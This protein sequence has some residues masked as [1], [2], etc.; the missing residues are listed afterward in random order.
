MPMPDPGSIT[1]VKGA[2]LTPLAQ[3]VG[4]AN[5]AQ[6]AEFNA[7]TMDA[8]VARSQAESQRSQ[9]GAQSDQFNLQKAQIQ[10]IE[11]DAAALLKDPRL[12]AAEADQN[13]ENAQAN[14]EKVLGALN[15]HAKFALGAGIPQAMVDQVLQPF[16]DMA[17][18]NPA[19]LRQFIM[20]RQLA[21]VGAQGQI[22]S[23]QP[24]IS[25]VDT[26]QNVVGVNTNQYAPQGPGAGV[27]TVQ[28]DV[29]VTQP[30]LLPNGQQGI[31]G[32]QGKGPIPTQLAP[33][34]A[35]A[36]PT[37]AGE[38]EAARQAL[39]AAPEMHTNNKMISDELKNVTA[40]GSAGGIISK[41]E[42]W[43]GAANVKGS[44]EA[45]RA[46]SAMDLIGKAFT[47]NMLKVAG[48]MGQMTN[49]KMAATAEAFGNQQFN[50]TAIRKIT[51]LNDALVSGAEAYQP[52]LEK[53]IA[54]SGGNVLAKRQYDQAWGQNFDPLVMQ[55]YNAK[56]SGNTAELND[57]LSSVGGPNSLQA[58]FLARK[59]K[60]LQMLSTQGR[61]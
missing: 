34:D 15:E 44:N 58:Q 60:N 1:P 54:A 50:P 41:A 47:R 53:A 56:K 19:N 17:Q 48:T 38:R 24:N 5:Q 7:R 25:Q 29:P 51:S 26:G 21:G 40:T 42:S 35:A 39:L 45:E 22:N 23:S 11:D 2:D 33:S 57:L 6:Q 18:K 8:R 32:T 12:V 10:R 36:L 30:V 27:Y 49:D 4:L 31:Q 55:I 46:A 37:L 3:I 20:A 61:L 43:F 28:K 16:R 59:A 13:P 14:S 9:T 52:G